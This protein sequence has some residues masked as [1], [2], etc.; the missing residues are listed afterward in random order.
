V[1]GRDLALK[2]LDYKYLPPWKASVIRQPNP[3][4]PTDPRDWALSE[5]ILNGTVKNLL[6][7]RHEIEHY[8]GKSLASI[9]QLVQKILAIA[10]YQLKFLDR[11]PASA[12]IDQAVEQTKRFGRRKSSGFVNA[13]LRNLER[14][15]PPEFPDANADPERYAEIALSHPRDLFRRLATLLG[16]DQ[17]LAFCRHDNTEP[18]MILRLYKGADTASL[19]QEWQ[20]LRDASKTKELPGI[21]PVEFVPH[22]QPGM[23]VVRNT[24]GTKILAHWAK[25]GLAQVQDPTAA[26]VVKKMQISPGM[27][28]LDCC[29]G[30]GTKT[31]QIQE[32]TTGEVVAF[33][34]SQPRMSR[35]R[36]LLDDRQITNV[37][38]VERLELSEATEQIHS[39]FD[40]ILADVPCSNT[41]VL[42]RRPEARYYL[43]NLDCLTKIQRRILDEAIPLLANGGILVY[44]TCSIL[45]EENELQLRDFLSRHPEFE[46]VEESTTWPGFNETAL[47]KYHD[48]GYCAVIR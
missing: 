33:D 28:V 30:F 46:R 16:N 10:F 23:F 22:E 45:P 44:S 25:L 2:L 12:A 19:L 5:Q 27:R 29:A 1:N 8:S 35:L 20:K 39:Q 47:E 40:R 15:P 43:S 11:I 4:L 34:P 31:L 13:V 6:R 48:G 26:A 7:L 21:Q 36:Q 14:K 37:R 24:R 38:L 41:G 17:A 32:Q 3:P 9:D 18:P 42:V